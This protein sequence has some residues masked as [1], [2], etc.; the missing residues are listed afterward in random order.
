MTAVLPRML[1]FT[2]TGISTE[3][4][5]PSTNE[6]DEGYMKTIN[7]RVGG[8][9]LHF[10]PYTLIFYGLPEF[11]AVTAVTAASNQSFGHFLS[12]QL[13]S[14]WTNGELLTTFATLMATTLWFVYW[15]HDHNYPQTRTPSRMVHHARMIPQDLWVPSVL[16]CSCFPRRS[17]RSGT[18][19]SAS[20]GRGFC[21]RTVRSDS[22]LSVVGLCM[23]RWPGSV[24][25]SLEISRM[26][27]S[28]RSRSMRNWK[29]CR[30]RFRLGTSRFPWRR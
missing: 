22:F 3:M 26:T 7:V 8:V 24:S 11:I 16:P 21:G 14:G 5:R 13:Q 2:V 30:T 18:P 4:S 15:I 29:S 27:P 20:R 6:F 23:W 12:Q 17:R 19:H 10:Y 9:V 1:S 28:P 25:M